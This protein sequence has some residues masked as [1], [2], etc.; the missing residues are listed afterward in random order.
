MGDLA[1]NGKDR[2]EVAQADSAPWRR[3]D[4][5]PGVAKNELAKIHRKIAAGELLQVKPLQSLATGNEKRAQ[6]K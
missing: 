2:V 4:Q 6:N 5:V 3:P 1:K